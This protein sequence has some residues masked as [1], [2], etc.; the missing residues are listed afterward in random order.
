MPIRRLALPALLWL[1][2][3]LDVG[4]AAQETTLHQWFLQNTGIKAEEVNGALRVS[5]GRGWIRTKPAFL[6]FVLRLQFRSVTE[7]AD[8]AIFIRAYPL[9]PNMDPGVG[10]RIALPMAGRVDVTPI[11]AYEGK[12]DDLAPPASVEAKPAGEWRDLEVRADG[13]RITITIDGTVV[14]TAKGSETWAGYVGFERRD[15]IME[16]RNVAIETLPTGRMCDRDRSMATSALVLSK[17]NGVASPRLRKSVRPR[18]TPDAIASA[19]EGIVRLEGVVLSDGTVGDVCVRRSLDPD[20][21]MQA[22]A[23][24]KAFEF[25]PGTRNGE[26][27]AV[28]V[29]FDIEFTLK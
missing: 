6:D 18:Y 21:D 5:G 13:P 8:G 22:V 15:G 27:V 2:P 29:S 4:A 7:D 19:K 17:G 10:Y 16:F 23:A 24:A 26:P 20:L 25:F 12:I 28:L 9:R 3:Q 14:R 1:L 11:K